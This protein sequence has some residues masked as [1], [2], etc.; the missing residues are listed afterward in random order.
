A[1]V[2]G[3]TREQSIEYA[4]KWDIPITVTKEKVYSIDENLW[5]KSI[6]CGIL[7]D[8][9]PVLLSDLCKCIKICWQAVHIDRLDCRCFLT[10]LFLRELG[11]EV[12]RLRIDVSK[13]GYAAGM[14]CSVCGSSETERCRDYLLLATNSLLLR[15]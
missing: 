11:I 13:D 2:W 8:P 7:E 10:D 9:A 14:D 6:E 15:N 5:G 1:R 12:E 3:L 4:A